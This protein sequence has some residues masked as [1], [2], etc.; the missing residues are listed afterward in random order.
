MKTL[1]LILFAVLLVITLATTM[2]AIHFAT[3]YNQAM[4]CLDD[5][6]ILLYDCENYIDELTDGTYG[7]TIT[8]GDS[9]SNFYDSYNQ[10]TGIQY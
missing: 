8:E 9:F 7:D 3:K 2:V 4:K 6:V 5:A 10:L 1:K